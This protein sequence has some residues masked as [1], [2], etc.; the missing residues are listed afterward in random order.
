MA[1]VT[2]KTNMSPQ[3]NRNNYCH[4]SQQLKP[5]VTQQSINNG[6]QNWR[7]N[8][9]PSFLCELCQKFGHSA[10][11]CRSKLHNH[12][13]A[14]AN[15]ASGSWVLN[16][17][18][19]IMSLPNHTILRTILAI[20]AYQWLMVTPFLLLILVHLLYKNLVLLFIF[21]ILCAP[22]IK[23]KHDFCRHVLSGQSNIC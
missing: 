16:S 13:E 11:A 2:Q 4:N 7:S 14:K 18:E 20:M 22:S 8:F 12:F 17:S 5:P 10:D 1:V 9:K 23:E 21:L 19:L 6:Q 3:S 15:F